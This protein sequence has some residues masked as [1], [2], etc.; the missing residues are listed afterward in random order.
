MATYSLPLS[1]PR[2]VT[3][4]TPYQ[5]LE[6]EAKI[7]TEFYPSKLTEAETRRPVRGFGILDWK[8]Q[9]EGKDQAKIDRRIFVLRTWLKNSVKDYAPSQYW[10]EDLY[11]DGSTEKW[12]HCSKLCCP[13]IGNSHS[14]WLPAVFEQVSG[15]NGLSLQEYYCIF[16]SLDFKMKS[17]VT[18]LL[19]R[20]RNSDLSVSFPQFIFSLW[21]Y[22]ILPPSKHVYS[23]RYFLSVRLI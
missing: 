6:L 16:G 14:L 10:Q 20:H 5:N 18:A 12:E 21:A 15:V 17:Q 7:P 22:R 13:E 4:W 3:I 11:P 2:K 8:I 1:E 9:S 19:A 23:Y